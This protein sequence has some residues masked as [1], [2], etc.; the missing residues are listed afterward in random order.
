LE[1]QEWDVVD[2][3]LSRQGLSQT[4]EMTWAGKEDLN[5]IPEALETTTCRLSRLLSL[6]NVIGPGSSL[7]AIRGSLFLAALYIFIFMTGKKIIIK[8][9]SKKVN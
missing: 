3:I 7:Q 4:M 6:K 2:G 1:A 8:A 9:Y 5:R